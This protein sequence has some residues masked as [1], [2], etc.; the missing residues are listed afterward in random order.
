M[1]ASWIHKLNESNSK[2]HKQDVLT[3]AL[4]AAVLGSDNADTFLKLAGMCYNPYVTF[5]VRKV[6]SSTTAGSENPWQDFIALLDDLKE[7]KI[8]GNA[9]IEAVENIA[10]RFN[11][12][13]WDNFCAPVIRRD[14]RAGFSVATINKVC[15]NTDYEVP[16]FK[17]QLATNSEGRPEMSGTKRL[18]PKLDGVRVL[19]VVSFEPGMYEHP[20][21]VAT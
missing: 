15:K 6:P 13:E 16:V 2:L 5:G 3:Q 10:E 1:S 8:T 11:D 4:E 18:E 19:M 14:L 12:D 9:A 17:C 21:P 7:R 20:E